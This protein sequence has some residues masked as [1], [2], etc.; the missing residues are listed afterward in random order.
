MVYCSTNN[1][2][3]RLVQLAVRKPWLDLLLTKL[4]GA[5]VHGSLPLAT[6]PQRFPAGRLVFSACH[7]EGC[8]FVMVDTV[9][10]SGAA[11]PGRCR[12]CSVPDWPPT[13]R[14]SVPTLPQ[15]GPCGYAASPRRVFSAPAL[16]TGYR[17]L[18]LDRGHSSRQERLLLYIVP[19]KRR[20][21]VQEGC[22]ERKESN[23]QHS[24]RRPVVTAQVVGTDGW[25]RAPAPPQSALAAS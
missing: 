23:L 6:A 11:T 17:A 10:G 13:R 24:E 8:G 19:Q 21:V 25:G 12:R 4:A 2:P 7:A 1:L 14:G 15:R 9:R 22:L 16:G 20:G 3:R 5:M 18:L